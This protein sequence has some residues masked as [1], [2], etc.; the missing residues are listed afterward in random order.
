MILGV[1]VFDAHAAVIDYE[2][3]TLFL[4]INLAE[5]SDAPKSPIGRE[6]ES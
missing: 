3:Q 5:H 4:R 1:D 2:T 6:F